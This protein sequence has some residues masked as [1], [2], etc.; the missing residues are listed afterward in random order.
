MRKRTYLNEAFNHNLRFAFLG[1]CLTFSRLDAFPQ[2]ASYLAAGKEGSRQEYLDG[3]RADLHMAGYGG[4]NVHHP[5]SVLQP[6]QARLDRQRPFYARIGK[7]LQPGRPLELITG[8]AVY[9]FSN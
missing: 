1:L 8:L 3:S 6:L 4:S 2:D 9:L 5:D 7:T